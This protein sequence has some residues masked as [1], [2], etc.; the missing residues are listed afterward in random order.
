MG[1]G[2]YNSILYQ[3]STLAILAGETFFELMKEMKEK[4]VVYRQR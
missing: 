1:F 2:N 4:E 3:Y